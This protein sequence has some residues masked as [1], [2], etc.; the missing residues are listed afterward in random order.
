M[1]EKRKLSYEKLSKV[2]GGFLISPGVPSSPKI[3]PHMDP[4]KYYTCKNC[5]EK[6]P[7]SGEVGDN[8]AVICPKCGWN[9]R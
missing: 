1:N 8:T 5:Q 2:N 7:K 4:G 3:E 9:V 6:I